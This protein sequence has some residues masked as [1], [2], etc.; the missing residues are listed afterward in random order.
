MASRLTIHCDCGTD[1]LIASTD[2][3]P[4]CPDCETAF[5]LSLV[6]LPDGHETP[7]AHAPSTHHGIVSYRGP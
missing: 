5:R 4:A 2:D 1:I 7:S 6:E 3:P